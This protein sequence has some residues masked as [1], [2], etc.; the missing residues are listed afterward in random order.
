MADYRSQTLA[1]AAVSQCL[2]LAD[3]IARTGEAPPELIEASLKSLF[4]F[5]A[6]AAAEVFS[7]IEGLETGLR[8]LHQLLSGERSPQLRQLLRYFMA[9]IHIHQLL[10]RQ[11][12]KIAIIRSR[13]AHTQ[14]GIGLHGFDANNIAHAAA[15]I[16]K[17]TVSQL[18]FRLRISGNQQYLQ[19]IR[20]AA[21]IRALLLAALRATF[22]WRQSGGNRLQM[23]FGRKKLL[24]QCNIMLNEIDA[25]SDSAD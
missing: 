13:L 3:A 2:W 23:T 20:L 1:L 5:E 15:G 9:V 25:P 16:Y 6:D 12:E 19:D 17:D 4:T 22:L 21:Q 10:R 7:D 24:Q 18:K 14:K 11:P 8:T